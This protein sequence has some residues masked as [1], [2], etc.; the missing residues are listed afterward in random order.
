MR[1]TAVLR[2]MSM[3]LERSSSSGILP[4]RLCSK[5]VGIARPKPLPGG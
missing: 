2:E 5:T 1:R 3:V 4:L